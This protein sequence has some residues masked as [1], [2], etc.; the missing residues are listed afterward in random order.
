[1]RIVQIKFKSAVP[2]PGIP[3]WGTYLTWN[4]GEGKVA[5]YETGSV[6]L[7]S[8]HA[9]GRVRVPTTNIDYVIEEDEVKV[10]KPVQKEIRQPTVTPGRGKK[11]NQKRARS[12]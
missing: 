5:T 7:S 9:P 3:G 8:P 4:E 1:M 10:S 11:G 6:V 2:I 12:A